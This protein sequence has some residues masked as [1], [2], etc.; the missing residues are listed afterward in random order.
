MIH[1]LPIVILLIIDIKSD[2]R[3]I[4]NQAKQLVSYIV[5]ESVNQE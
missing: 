1:H 3:N 4:L 5:E 2:L